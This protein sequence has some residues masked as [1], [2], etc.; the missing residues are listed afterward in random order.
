M[1]KDYVNDAGK[2]LLICILAA[3]GVIAGIEGK[4]EVS[5]GCTT[6]IVLAIIFL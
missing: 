2:W 3:V 5:S 4:W 1:S 6:V